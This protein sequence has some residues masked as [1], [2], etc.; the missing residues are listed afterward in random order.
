M[1][2]A[3]HRPNPAVSLCFVLSHKARLRH[4]LTA[5]Y[6]ACSQFGAAQPCF[7]CI[8]PPQHCVPFP[9]LRVA[10][11]HCS[12]SLAP[13]NLGSH[14]ALPVRYRPTCARLHPGGSF[15]S[16]K[17]YCR[18]PSR[19]SEFLAAVIAAVPH[20][21]SVTPFYV[22]RLHFCQLLRVE[23]SISHHFPTQPATCPTTTPAATSPA[24][25]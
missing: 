1:S 8:R 11:P 17:S 13:A 14:R 5:R 18:H 16:A 20:K 2:G 23:S 21:P 4:R 6:G 24:L 15:S 10:Q 22:A 7:T 9:S 25:P 19:T 12:Q 3:L